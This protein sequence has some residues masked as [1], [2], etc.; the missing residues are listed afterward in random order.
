MGGAF[1]PIRPAR[2]NFDRRPPWASST[3]PPSAEAGTGPAEK[4]LG[5]VTQ[6]D[7]AHDVLYL[8]GGARLGPRC[9]TM[10]RRQARRQGQSGA[11][12]RRKPREDAQGQSPE[13]SHRRIRSHVVGPMPSAPGR[14]SWTVNAA[15]FNGKPR[16]AAPSRTGSAAASTAAFSHSG[17]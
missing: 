4:G 9:R 17:R 6:G 15:E 16:S 2:E 11:E 1:K 7:D 10:R 13:Q 8:P 14:K 5:R 12:G 3:V